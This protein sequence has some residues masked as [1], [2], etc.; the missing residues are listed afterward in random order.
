MS[1]VP[2]AAVAEIM[3]GW[4]A[5]APPPQFKMSRK[6]SLKS[7]KFWSLE[8]VLGI[9]LENFDT[10]DLTIYLERAKLIS[11]TLTLLS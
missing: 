5:I 11:L 7:R 1:Q 2:K 10:S 8:V 6:F 4:G 9:Q 3:G